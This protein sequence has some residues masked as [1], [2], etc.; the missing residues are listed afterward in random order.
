MTLSLHKFGEYFPGTGAIED[1]GYETGKYYSVNCPLSDGM[2][3][4]HYAYVFEQIVD[5]IFVTF[6]PDAVFMQCGGDSLSGDRLGCFNLSV[7]GHGACVDYMKK[8]NVPMIVSG[9]G[10]YTLRNVPRAWT[11]ETSVCLG[12]DIA[13]E[14][15]EDNEYRDYFCPEYKIHMSTSNMEN[16]NSRTELEDKIAKIKQNLKNVT[17]KSVDLSNYQNGGSQVPDHM[18]FDANKVR[19]KRE[20]EDQDINTDLKK[21]D[22]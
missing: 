22:I 20:E 3:D 4:V 6:R 5:E 16:L 12:V 11:Y 13:N 2:D 7:K 14:I 8:K 18:D 17:A 1:V 21:E 15:P 10:G 9:G 19:D